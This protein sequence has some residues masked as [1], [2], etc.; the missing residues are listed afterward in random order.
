MIR[1]RIEHLEQRCIQRGCTLDD[2]RACVV[3]EDGDEIVVDETHEAYP[4]PSPARPGSRLAAMLKKAGFSQS[5]ACGCASME[6][7]MNAMGPQ[8][9]LSV[10]GM[11][12]IVATMRAEHAKLAKAGGTVL[13]WS[14]TAAR[15]MVRL[16]C[17]D[18]IA[19]GRKPD[20]DRS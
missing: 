13:P 3:S 9:C 18:V 11:S 10:D 1:C 8:W 5:P 2:V 15:A 7:R 12:E 4:K 6:K 14:E 20:V 17:S 16:A 19:W